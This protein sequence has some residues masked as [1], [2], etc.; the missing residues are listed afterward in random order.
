MISK[1]GQ[2]FILA[3][4]I[5]ATV[6]YGL[7]ATK[8]FL[9]GNDKPQDFFILG[10]QISEELNA[11]IDYSVV[12]GKDNISDFINQ[13]M[14]YV[15]TSKSPTEIVF[16]YTNGTNLFVENYA[17][18]VTYVSGFGS[19]SASSCSVLSTLKNNFSLNSGKLV[20]I[21]IGSENYLYNLSKG[22]KSY[23]VLKRTIGREVYIDVK[24]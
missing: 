2:F 17:K 23:I 22:S 7:T 15:N 12:S 13:V 24:E 19:C 5:I 16:L 21:S 14:V 6:V 4:V 1:R 3:A 8:S 9:S 18:N 11:V 20:N 10:E